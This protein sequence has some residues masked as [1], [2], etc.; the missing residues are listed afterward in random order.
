LW[1]PL[2]AF[3]PKMFVNPQLNITFDEDACNTGAIVNELAVYAYAFGDE[4]SNLTSIH[5][6]STH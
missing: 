1:D 2:L 4:L 3:D 5:K 6:I